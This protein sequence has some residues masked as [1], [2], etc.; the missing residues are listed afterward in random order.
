MARTVRNA[1]IDTRSARA[2]LNARR[3]P[4]WT[5][6]SPGMALGYRKGA[7][8]GTWIARL[9]NANSKPKMRYH[10][11]GAADDALDADGVGSLSFSQAQEKARPWFSAEARKAEGLAP[12]DTGP[13]TVASVLD[14]YLSKLT[15]KGPAAHK[16]TQYRVDALIRPALG[17]IEVRKLTSDRLRKF[18][19]DQ[20]E[21][22]AR[23]RTRAG[24]PQKSRE[25]PSS[26]AQRARKASANRTWTVLRAALNHAFVEGKVESDAVWRRVKPFEDVETARVRYLTVGQ[27]QR[28][29]NACPSEFRDLVTAALLT[30]CRYGEL[31]ALNVDDYDPDSGSVLV[32]RSKSGKS[33]HV[34]LTDEGNSYFLRLTA[35]REAEAPMLKKVSGGRWQRSHQGRPMREACKAAR[36]DPPISFHGLRHTYASLAAMRGAPLP[37]IAHNLGHTSTRMVEKHY[38]HLGASYLAET[39]RDKA[40][41]FGVQ[42]KEG[43]MPIRGRQT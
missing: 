11:L 17:K 5:S 20:A 13:Y 23:L 7:T 3:E 8:G 36:I 14:D 18:L 28:L 37:V 32:R 29:M 39:I 9:Y 6:I 33:R 34:Y 40:P 42:P 12:V 4:Y 10:S 25:A 27:S 21:A 35:G 22:P 43:V 16:D 31:I 24:E 38:G 1:K 2:K 19:M 30:G 41:T 15:S 26:D